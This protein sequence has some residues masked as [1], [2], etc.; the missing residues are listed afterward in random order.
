MPFTILVVDDQDEVKDLMVDFLSDYNGGLNVLCASTPDDAIELAKTNNIDILITDMNLQSHMSGSDVY[1]KI[2]A[3]H[4]NIKAVFVT[5]YCEEPLSELYPDIP[6][7]NKPFTY[8]G[9]VQ[10]VEGV[11]EHV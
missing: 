8:E 3:I 11:L 2:R 1:E 5:A 6:I 9:F 7:L 10:V 4:P